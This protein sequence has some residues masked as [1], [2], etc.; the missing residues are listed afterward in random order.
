MASSPSR[1]VEQPYLRLH[2]QRQR[3]ARRFSSAA[4]FVRRTADSEAA[5]A[6]KNPRRRLDSGTGPPFLAGDPC[7]CVAW[8]TPAISWPSHCQHPLVNRPSLPTAGSMMTIP[9]EWFFEEPDGL[10]RLTVVPALP[11]PSLPRRRQGAI[12]LP[13]NDLGKYDSW[14]IIMR[15]KQKTFQ[16]TLQKG[17]S[18]SSDPYEPGRSY[19]PVIIAGHRCLSFHD[20]SRSDFSARQLHAGSCSKPKLAAKAHRATG[21]AFG[22]DASWHRLEARP[23]LRAPTRLLLSG[24]CSK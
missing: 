24:T 7:K 21:T 6:A 11:W 10:R 9:S 22:D 23:A 16:G 1:L 12:T 13:C 2:H 3:D 18:S 19:R 8:I 5:P 20:P 14:T 4:R 17:N 15:F